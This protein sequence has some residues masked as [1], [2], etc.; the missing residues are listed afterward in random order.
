M[1]WWI[2]ITLSWHRSRKSSW[3]H[4]PQSI[5]IARHVAAENLAP[6]MAD[7]KEAV[8]HAKGERWYRE[9]VHGCNSLAMVPQKRQPT[10][11]QIWISRNSSKPS[12][13]RGFRYVEAQLY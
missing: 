9:E 5:G 11:G 3:L 4:D 2:L 7:H 1:K 8:Q 6:V 10:L 12:R 13:H